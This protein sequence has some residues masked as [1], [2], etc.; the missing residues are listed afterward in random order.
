MRSPKS[1]LTSLRQAVSP[2]PA[3]A[4][5]NSNSGSSTW[6]RDGEEVVPAAALDL[7]VLKGRD[8][9]ERLVTRLVLVVAGQTS[10]HTPQPVQSSGATWMVSRWPGRSLDRNGLWGRSE[11]G[12]A[13]IASG[14]N[15][16]M[17][18]AEWGHTLVYLPQSMQTSESQR[19]LLG[20]G[21]RLLGSGPGGEGPVD[22][23]GA[24][25]DKVALAGQ[26]PGGDPLHEVGGVVGDREG[27]R[28]LARHPSGTVTRCSPATAASMAAKFRSTTSRPRCP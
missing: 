21:S 2:Q 27:R 8:H 9:V 28:P 10:T 24:D 7:T 6:E 16:F 18:S 4:P 23:Q 5:E 14:A 26:E 11:S 1:W 20:D 12:I 22:G 25:G 15:T 19:D 13:S 17:R 3:Q